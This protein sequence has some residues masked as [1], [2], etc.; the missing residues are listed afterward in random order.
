MCGTPSRAPIGRSPSPWTTFSASPRPI[1]SATS[2]RRTST[3][4]GT[5]AWLRRHTRHRPRRIRIEAV[6]HRKQGLFQELVDEVTLDLAAELTGGDLLG[7]LG[8]GGPEL[9]A[10]PPPA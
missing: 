10:S 4:S 1:T 6:L 5:S 9:R 2:S 3:R 8:L 7:L